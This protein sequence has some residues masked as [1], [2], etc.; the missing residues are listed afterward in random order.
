[1]R[2]LSA[3]FGALLFV[4]G[5]ALLVTGAVTALNLADD[6]TSGSSDWTCSAQNSEQRCDYSVGSLPETQAEITGDLA[7]TVAGT[8][9]AICGAIFVLIGSQRAPR[10]AAPVPAYP[11]MQQQYPPR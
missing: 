4:A 2:I 7:L 5:M 8:G 10:P 3:V 9:I 6:P 1:M 11:P